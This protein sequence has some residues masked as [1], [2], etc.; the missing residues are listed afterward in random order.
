MEEFPIARL[1]HTKTT[2]T[3]ALY[4]RDRDVRFHRYGPA[5][6]S[7]DVSILLDEIGRD[8]TGIFWG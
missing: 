8:H 4:Y 3:W 2:G 1:R 6:P 7:V 5:R